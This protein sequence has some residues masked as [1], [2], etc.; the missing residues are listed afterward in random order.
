MHARR[1]ALGLKKKE[2]IIMKWLTNAKSFAYTAYNYKRIFSIWILNW[3]GKSYRNGNYSLLF[4][5]LN[6]CT[7]GYDDEDDDD[8][9]CFETVRGLPPVTIVIKGFVRWQ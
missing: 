6:V 8:E 7:L 2:E 1:Y 3:G 9:E 4:F 5:I